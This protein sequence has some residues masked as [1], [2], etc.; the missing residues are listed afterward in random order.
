MIITS[1][2][3]RSLTAPALHSSMS[4]IS[5]R[6]S[7]CLYVVSQPMRLASRMS[8]ACRPSTWPSVMKASVS[9]TMQQV[10]S[11]DNPSD[12][13]WACAWF[14][15]WLRF[16][17]TKVRFYGFPLSLLPNTGKIPYTR[18]QPIQHT[19]FFVIKP[20]RCSNFT[21]LFCHETLHVLDSSS[22]HHQEFI[23]CTLSNGICHTGV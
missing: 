16:S 18:Q 13:Y 22:V 15:S 10:S 17:L 9:V 8:D 11:S 5:L 12:L 6:H 7:S 1:V 21:N 2:I 19:T 3:V 14:Q 23:H 4:G 20:T